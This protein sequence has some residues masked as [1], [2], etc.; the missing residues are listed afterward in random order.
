MLF[1]ASIDPFMSLMSLVFI[2]KSSYGSFFT[3]LHVR[4]PVLLA[5]SA[6]FAFAVV[7]VQVLAVKLLTF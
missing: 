4:L 5:S 3:V 2:N 7:L 6:F 1:N